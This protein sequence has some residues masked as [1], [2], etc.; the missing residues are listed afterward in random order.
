MKDSS[1]T[2]ILESGVPLSE[3]LVWRRQRQFYAQRGMRA[4]AE[5]HVPCFLTSN[6]FIAEIYARIVCGFLR[7]CLVVGRGE[8]PTVSP[9]KPLRILELGAGT[10]KFAFLF[11]RHL[12]EELRT[13]G[14]PPEMIRYCMTDCSE[15]LVTA[16]RK[17]GRLCEFVE[18]GLLEFDLFTV[19]DSTRSRFAVG[20]GAPESGLTSGPLVVIANYVFDSLPQDAFVIRDVQIFEALVTTTS[21]GVA[22]PDG[23]SH[24]QLTYDNAEM[25][26]NRYANPTWNEIL[27]G[28]RT[29]LPAATVLFPSEALKI[30]QELGKFAGGRMLVLAAD[31][32]F[33]HEEDLGLSQGPPTPEWH[34]SSNCFS[35]TVNF[36]AVAKHFEARG[37]RAL[38]PEKHST[39]L[40]ICGFVQC[41]EGDEFPAATA[42]YRSSQENFGVD[43]LFVLLAWLN[44]HM[45]EIS[46]QQI[47]AVLRLSRWDPIALLR[48]FP[49][50]A[51]QLRS[52]VRER[53]DLREAVLRT[54]ANYYPVQPGENILAFQCGVT[55][56][57]LRFFEEAQLMF[58]TSE[59]EAGRS[60]ATSYNLGL[61]SLGLGRSAE[62]LSLVVEACS[63]DSAFEPARVLRRK[64]E[65]GS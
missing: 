63:L 40:N 60:A 45:E 23:M 55:L 28:Y 14:F 12:T 65:Q 59:R 44:A 57:E 33:V 36:D 10:G 37:G 64:L 30:M 22:E 46:P 32:G 35:L 49:V 54:W 47:L 61:C 48:L 8:V 62:A 3:S 9:K 11:L 27:E 26:R 6:P 7:D 4:W 38:L 16:W 13:E 21:G 1:G 19:G 41:R 56:L 34:A 58:R 42:A 18:R 17:N 52:A 43:D 29:R 53:H 39:N 2:A 20:N 51:R 15:T 50:L 31:K 24:L 5:D 25:A